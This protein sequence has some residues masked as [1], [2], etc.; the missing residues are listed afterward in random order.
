MPIEVVPFAAST[1]MLKIK[2]ISGKPTLR[3]SK[4]KVG[5]VI[6]DNGNII[7]DANFGIIRDPAEL[8]LKLKN[9]PGVVE[10]G[11]FIEMTDTVYIGKHLT[12]ERIQKLAS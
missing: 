6:T 9:L 7:I 5:P 4:K 3:E 1:I 10:T 12:V 11:L 8:D 2:E